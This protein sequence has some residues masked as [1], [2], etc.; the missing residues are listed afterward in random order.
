M[1]N[2]F[3][4]V[5]AVVRLTKKTLQIIS[6]PILGLFEAIVS[7][8]LLIAFTILR[9]LEAITVFTKKYLTP[10]ACKLYAAIQGALKAIVEQAI[11]FHAF[12]NQPSQ[13]IAWLIK[14]INLMLIP[15]YAIMTFGYRVFLKL[16]EVLAQDLAGLADLLDK[17][18]TTLSEKYGL[19]SADSGAQRQKFTE[20]Y[21]AKSLDEKYRGY[22]QVRADQFEEEWKLFSEELAQV[23]GQ[24]KQVFQNKKQKDS[25][26]QLSA[27]M[28]ERS[29]IIV[30]SVLINIL[31][32]A[33][34]LLMLQLYDRILS[35]RSVDTLIVFCVAVGT[36]VALEAVIRIFRSY[37]TAWISARFEHQGY[38]SLTSRL[39]AEPIN[40]FERKGTGAI[41][42][43]YKSISTLRYHYS[44][45][46]FQQL[47]DLPFTALYV[48]II[49]FISPLIGI[50]LL[51]GYTAFVFITWKNGRNY[52]A[53]I[54]EQKEMDLRRGNLL[55]E[56]LKN[57]HTM[58]S[59]TMESLMLRRYER[60]QE[61]CAILMSRVTYA[62]EMSAGVGSV[63]SPLMTVVVVA[64]G[65]WLV[66]TNH[67]SNGEMAGCIMLGLR[68]LAPLQRLGGMWSKHQQ[69]QI[70]RDKLNAALSKPGLPAHEKVIDPNESG[71]VSQELH[72]S[73][74]SLS[75]V[76][77]QFPG[78]KKDIFENLSLDIPAGECIAIGG[79]SGSGRSALLQLMAGILQPIEGVVTL[80]GKNLQDF[81]IEDLAKE[82]AYLPQRTALFEGSLLDNVT[83]FDS[84]RIDTAM[85]VAKDLGLSDFVSRMPRGWDSIVGDMAAD[86]MPPGFR[87]RVAIVRALSSNP[88]VILFDDSS[89][90]MDSEGD[91]MLLK[92][93]ESIRGKVTIVLVSERPSFVRLANRTLYL[94]DGKL[95]DNPS[96]SV[97]PLPAPAN[98]SLTTS[99]IAPVGALPADYQALPPGAFFEAGRQP[100]LPSQRWS[101]MG[102]TIN[103]NFKQL[104]DFSECLALLLKV[105]NSPYSARDV[106]ESLP[107][108]APSLDLTGIQNAM[109]TLGYQVSEVP[110][111]LSEIDQRAFP[112]LF[113]PDHGAAFVVL[114][115]IGQQ[116]RVGESTEG[117]PR[118]MNDLAM[119]GTAYFFHQL[120]K[121]AAKKKSWVS[122]TLYR[123]AGLI[124][125]GSMAS[126]ISGVILMGSSL[127][128]M[129]AYSVVIPSGAKETLFYLTIGAITAV[130]LSYYFV[131]QRADILSFISG[132]IE[133]LFGTAVLQHVLA[134]PPSFSERAS[135]GAQSARL[136]IFQGIRDAFTGP[137]ASTMLE[138]PATLVLLIGLSI[139]NP[140]ALVLFVVMVAVYALLFFIFLK[141][142]NDR[143]SELGRA[144]AKR[145]EFLIEMISKMRNV[146]ESGA[147]YMWL[148]RMREVSANSAMCSFQA[149]R[150]SS[151]LVGISYFV[152][153][154]SALGIVAF[155]TPAVF[156]QKLSSGAL[157][158][159]MLLMWRVLTPLQTLFT[160]MTRI[161]RIRSAAKQI[162]SLMHIQTERPDEISA[163]PVS[164]GLE[165]RLEFARVSFRYSMHT[166]PALIG[167]EFKVQAGES[168]AITGANGSGKSTLLK[169]LMGM[170]A[171][172]A[173]SILIDGVDI[174]Q[175]DPLELRR[176][177]GYAPQDTQFF[178]AT[179]AQN[180]RLA[181]PD[182][183]D[184][185]IYQVLD[186]A[187]ALTAVMALPNGI[188]YR[189]GDNTN[190]LP[191]TLKQKLLLARTYITRAPIMIFDEPGSGLDA[192]GDHKFV[193]T[194]KSLKGKTTVLFIS[195]RPSHIRLADTLL[196]FDKGYLRAAGPPNELL[197][198]PVSA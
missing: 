75:N 27:F 141:R 105:I 196:V 194:L 58:K 5:S 179:I 162:D 51:I 92:Y 180:L 84:S 122:Q 110:C 155:T 14:P 33:F 68:A 112:C 59:M 97:S 157:I 71:V 52:P 123:F 34:P 56:I 192:E 55:T 96:N 57:V 160:N 129:A 7:A 148:E 19:N 165:G 118:L 23:Y 22:F 32:L 29:N 35:H 43:E 26:D 173:G 49:L 145:T 61:S 16:H 175:L 191:S 82:V 6:L 133:Y 46:T 124:G 45:Q 190:E 8:F 47:M 130:I 181:R 95:F 53:I 70:L 15:A 161:E 77:F 140:I 109:A 128:L 104:T 107:Y 79:Q 72:A 24:V 197:K 132:R 171:P 3:N 36:A 12:M 172:Q 167:I 66:I 13:S 62:L 93:I 37:A 102:D 152:M 170:Y 168:V 18:W 81:S 184:D 156:D 88:S 138:L 177:I 89:A 169:L 163:S 9:G 139:I 101:H 147:Q 183:T 117:D 87:Q 54:K 60:L 193:E 151:M 137:L 86:S 189:F 187:G 42:E 2:N 25:V 50:V 182:A 121:G 166:D 103:T 116:L 74:L 98:A 198:Q 80:N 31:A 185:D 73:S 67:L 76:A 114:G 188:N 39:L 120:E 174:R 143:V 83:V 69:D 125:Q 111:T 131:R 99:D 40:E 176:V 178:R 159:S 94:H 4:L 100:A 127:F 153:M 126:L 186:M 142:T 1:K 136:Q 119:P 38:V 158:A 90:A 135:V 44:G 91:A 85:R 41:L 30:A 63:F 144:S 154:L 149:E 20:K 195:H 164:R 134:L 17:K 28:Q 11:R 10:L 48:F 65:S 78:V 64:L 150:L 106:A 21:S 108:Y 146:R 113:V 115:R